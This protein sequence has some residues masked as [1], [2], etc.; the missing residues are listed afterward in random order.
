M[1]KLKTDPDNFLKSEIHP[2]FTTRRWCD[3][4]R[5]GRGDAAAHKTC[6][7]I[8]GGGRGDGSH[9]P[10]VIEARL[11]VLSTRTPRLPIIDPQI[12]SGRAASC[13]RREEARYRHAR[14]RQAAMY[15]TTGREL[16][17]DTVFTPS[18]E[19]R[20]RHITSSIKTSDMFVNL[21]LSFLYLIIN[22]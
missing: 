12:I 3:L 21:N 7:L 13:P 22:M 20:S 9:E 6:N 2:A 16:T 18:F 8:R 1:D 4:K 14:P 10:G 17:S 11:L 19:S 5:R 15:P